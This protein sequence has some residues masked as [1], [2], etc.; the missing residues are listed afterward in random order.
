MSK[1]HSM[2]KV[3]DIESRPKVESMNAI[4]EEAE[5]KAPTPKISFF[6]LFRY[7]TRKD[8]ALMI[9]GTIM[10]IANGVAL[11]AF[12]LLFGD[13]TDA[14]HEPGGPDTVVRK[15][16]GVAL[17]FLYAGIGSWVASYF[18]L[19]FWIAAGQRQA[20][21]WRKQYF[22]A[23]LR[24]EIAWYDLN[25]PNELATRVSSECQS[26]QGGIGEKCAMF[27]YTISTVTAGFVLGFVK[28]WQ[29]TLVLCACIPVIS[30][31][32][33]FFMM[34]MQKGASRTDEAYAVSGARAEEALKGI[35]TVQALGGEE[36][37]ISLY[38]KTLLATKAVVIKF[39][40]YAGL[41]LGIIFAALAGMYSLGFW[42]GSVL[43]EDQTWN[44]VTGRPYSPGDVLTIFFSVLMGAFSMSQLTPCAKAF[45]LAKQSGAT[46]IAIIDRKSEISIEDPKGQRLSNLQ[47]DVSFEN[48]TFS[49]PRN[50]QKQ[51]LKETTFHI[52]AN[53]KTA[54]VG[55]SG[56]G[57]STI[58]QLIERFYDPNGGGSVKLD[59]VDLKELNLQWLRE[60]IGYVGQEP[61]LF[62]TSIRENLQYAKDNC[63]E[64]EIIEALK[65][66]NIYQF[67]M[68]LER[69]LDTF[70]GS[71]G[72]QLSGGQKQ[73]LAIARAILKN[74]KILLLDE[75]T[76]ALDRRNER[77]IQETL[78]S[79]TEGRTTIV[80]AHRLTTIENSDK[81]IVL[82]N[83]VVVEE[84]KH[85]DLMNKRGRYY[86]LEQLQIMNHE[87]GS[88]VKSQVESEQKPMPPQPPQAPVSP[89]ELEAKIQ[90]QQIDNKA[91]SL[92]QPEELQA[93]SIK[94]AMEPL[95]IEIDN[96]T[97]VA[98]KTHDKKPKA[99]KN[100]KGV[101]SRLL[102]YNKDDRFWM[103]MGVL[104][105]LVNGCIFPMFALLL[106][107]IL[108]IISN[109]G[110]SDF[111][112][113]ANFIAYMYL[114][115]GAGFIIFNS[116]Q[117][118]I[119]TYIA[120]NLSTKLRVDFFR[121]L[122]KMHIGWH[123]KQENNAAALTTKLAK[124]CTLVNTLTS[125]VLGVTIQSFSSFVTGMAIAF[126]A[127]WQLTLV[128]LGISPLLFASG[129]LEANM[130]K[131]FSSE[132][133]EAYKEAGTFIGETVINM[134]TVASFGKEGNILRSYSRKLDIPLQEGI[135]GGRKAGFLFGFSQFA[136]FGTFALVFYVGAIFQQ[137][138]GLSFQDMFQAIFGVMFAAMGSGNATQ[139]MPDVG[140]AKAAAISLF[141]TID[142]KPEIDIDNPAQ[143]VKTEIKGNVEFKNVGFKYPSRDLKV[144]KDLS[145][146]VQLGKKVALVGPSGC[147]KS[148]CMQL[149]MRFYDVTEGAILI[150]GVD[151]R[152]YDLR[153]LRKSIGLVAQ[154]PVVFTGSIEYNIRYNMHD[155]SMEQ[156][157][158][159]ATYANALDFDGVV[160][161]NK[162]DPLKR[163]V[164]SKGSLISGGQKQ[165]IAIARTILRNP[166]LLLLDEATSALDSKNEE[167][168]QKALNLLMQGRTSISVAHRISTIKDSDEI[169]VFQEGAIVERGTYN[170]LV[171]AAGYFYRLERGE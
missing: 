6:Q 14:F 76:S 41:S 155:V 73:R 68:S 140:G 153:H 121:K 19:A 114:V 132:S 103:T 15:V 53:K 77:E 67:V 20:M 105:A 47:G 72:T 144:F 138:I 116:L 38:K 99:A 86:D 152:Q 71:G 117:L 75:A 145:F 29:L 43:I 69:K 84:G 150:D 3:E 81:I 54:I 51:I 89:R 169:L 154:E 1:E 151:I 108:D 100:T 61:A 9:I 8:Y 5:K 127:S 58:M 156:I 125:T 115:C 57:K 36:H 137:H 122:L 16:G 107:R 82:D 106:S 2:V 136:K 65:K 110:A 129:Y 55:G 66:A 7:A 126:A 48:I 102:S 49:Y 167:L 158:Q 143:N 35:R 130:W 46:A 12:S 93:L 111:R 59:G 166:S 163:A 63:T 146:Y 120:E 113:R 11:P 97:Q 37:E 79:L 139:F 4:P 78:D 95:N 52:E 90:A 40:V 91:I 159:A 17:D 62:A 94:P 80:V 168:V 24:Q 27:A 124:D 32:G 141:E 171:Q 147:G 104:S 28:G 164:G 18:Q 133:G 33:T 88:F 13:I 30:V 87:K 64:E 44:S 26:I 96:G 112:S 92:E 42:Y 160:T 118:G 131:G 74:P 39:G 10:A 128:T 170:E 123:D 60:N 25:N 162:V 135:K 34:S 83:G 21:A 109:P 22:R 134:R 50:L 45:A 119:F 149:L 161:D 148:T 165:R 85:Q 56:S 70:V 142:T 31:A 157:R 101:I 98:T 23:L